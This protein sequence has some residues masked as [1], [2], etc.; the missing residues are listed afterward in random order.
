[1]SIPE[2]KSVLTQAWTDISGAAANTA[3]VNWINDGV[4]PV[5]IAFKATAPLNSDPHVTLQRGEAYY[6]KNGSAKIW[7]MKLTDQPGCV[8]SFAD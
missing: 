2:T 5:A 7:G 8:V 3:G 1:M 4:S 6:D